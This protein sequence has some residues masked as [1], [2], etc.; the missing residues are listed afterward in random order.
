MSITEVILGINV[1]IIQNKLIILDGECKLD[2]YI[3]GLG[4]K[5]CVHDVS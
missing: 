1:I 4:A 5:I 2:I 3:I